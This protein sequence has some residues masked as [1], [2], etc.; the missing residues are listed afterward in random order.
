MKI[1]DG[2]EIP[3][4]QLASLITRQHQFIVRVHGMPRAVIFIK[5]AGV[6]GQHGAAL[7]IQQ[8]NLRV[9]SRN[10]HRTLVLR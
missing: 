8:D 4:E 7:A 9:Q 2:R 10:Q 6:L 5:M 1:T 3:G